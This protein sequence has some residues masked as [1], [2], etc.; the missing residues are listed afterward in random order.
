MY[1][2]KMLRVQPPLELTQSNLNQIGAAAQM[3]F[4]IIIGADQPRNLTN[5]YLHHASTTITDEQAKKRLD[6]L[7]LK[8]MQGPVANRKFSP[9]SRLNQAESYSRQHLTEAFTT[10][11]LE[12]IIERI[13]LKCSNRVIVI[14]RSKDHLGIVFDIFQNLQAGQAWHSHIQKNQIRTQCIDESYS[15]VTGRGFPHH[16]Q[17]DFTLQKVLNCL[18]GQR[19]IF[20]D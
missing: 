12:N 5:S 4:D 7:C 19:F 1:A 15:P 9:V 2:T 6:G 14:S 11:R 10:E 17:P 16:F 8:R 18:P 13:Q 20:N 3:K